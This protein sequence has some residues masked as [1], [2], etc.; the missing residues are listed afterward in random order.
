MRLPLQPGGLAPGAVACWELC[1]Q[2]VDPATG[3]RSF[4]SVHMVCP[5]WWTKNGAPQQKLRGTVKNAARL[6]KRRRGAH[7]K[8]GLID[9]SCPEAARRDRI[10]T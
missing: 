10:R 7:A 9:R 2:L 6:K 4:V 1:P 3:I 5:Q 8:C